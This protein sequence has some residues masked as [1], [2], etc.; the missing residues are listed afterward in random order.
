[1]I[2]TLVWCRRSTPQRPPDIEGMKCSQLA[3]P[4]QE[5]VPVRCLGLE[6]CHRHEESS[7]ELEHSDSQSLECQTGSPLAM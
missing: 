6:S 7:L 2:E 3:S 5:L 4:V 1:M